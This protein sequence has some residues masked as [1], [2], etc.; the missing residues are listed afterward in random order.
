[1]TGMSHMMTVHE[2]KNSGFTL[3]EVLVAVLVAGIVLVSLFRMQSGSINLAEVD[4]FYGAASLLAKKQLAV[5]ENKHFGEIESSGD[6]E[7]PYENYQWESTISDVDFQDLLT[8]SDNDANVLKKIEL[9]IK[10]N[11]DNRAYSITTFRYV[12]EN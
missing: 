1:M 3:M 7:P 11:D 8:G 2:R 6:F 5:M 9:E 4:K 10:D 12:Y